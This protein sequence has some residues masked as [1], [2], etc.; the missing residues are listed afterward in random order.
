MRKLALVWA[1]FFFTGFFPLFP[2]TFASFIVVMIYYYFLQGVSP[3]ILVASVAIITVTG[4][5]ASSYAETYH[6]KKDP[7][8]VVID[9]VAGQLL[10]LVFSSG[11]VQ[12]A[13]AFVL[14]RLFDALKPFPIKKAE[15]IGGGLG[16]MLDDIVAGLYALALVS[17]YRFFC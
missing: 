10:A 11:T 7:R 16:I 4:I 5:L 14:F 2:G 9:E 12:I 6:G 15:K 17:L 1:H 13:F 8:S 3:W